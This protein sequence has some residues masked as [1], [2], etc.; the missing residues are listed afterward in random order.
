[1]KLV[2]EFRGNTPRPLEEL[3]GWLAGAHEDALEPDLP[4]VDPHHHIWDG[5]H[6]RYLLDEFLRDLRSGHNIVSTVFVQVKTMYRVDASEA[7]KPVGEMEFANGIA[8]ASASGY[9]GKTR[10][11]EGIVGFADLLLGDVVEPVLERLI[12]A[13]NGRLRGIRQGATWDSGSAAYGRKFG[14]RHLLR[15]ASFRKGFSHLAS[16][17]LSFD[18]W[19]YYHQLPDLVDLLCTFPETS[20][21]LDHAGGILGIA[22]HTDR[23]AVFQIWQSNLRSLARFPNLTIKIGG[24]GMLYNGWDFHVRESPPSSIEL[25]NA[26]RPYVEECIE[27]F[28]PERCMFESN[29]PVDKQSCGY[30]QL[31]NA[32]KRITHEFSVDEKAAL[33]HDTAARIY[34]LGGEAMRG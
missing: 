10:V 21:V 6:G 33:Y 23:R 24:L 11:C 30:G 17:G 34:R 4:I 16:L 20:V 18:A 8:A 32:F 13:G 19:L 26:W 9:Y 5:G 27:I 12:R 2:P 25:A 1:M 14:P 15:E 28:G 31:W 22:P 7:M 29:F 3:D